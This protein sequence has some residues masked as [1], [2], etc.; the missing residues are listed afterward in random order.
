MSS[1][2][3]PD[4]T[5]PLC[6][7]TSRAH[8]ESLHATASRVDT[9]ILIEYRG[10]WAHDAVDGSTLS[11]ELKDYL[12]AERV[13]LPRSRI[14][15][16]RSTDRRSTDGLVAYVARS[17]AARARASLPRAGAARR[18]DRPRPDDGRHAGRPP[19]LP[20]LHARQARPLLRQVRP[21]AL[22]RRPRAGGRRLGVAVVARRRRPLRGES[23]RPRRRCLLRPR[24]A[25]GGLA[26]GRGG[27]RA[28]RAPAA[29]PWPL[30]LRLRRSGGRDRRP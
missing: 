1:P 12:V 15:F 25:G 26:R 6:A 8:A 28:A 27:A 10:L 22:R 20:R 9:W 18:P 29:L 2:T 17:T 5:K 23:R 24:R 13:R 4:S 16:V 3:R 11:R 30:L 21:A 14:L 7:E 19:A